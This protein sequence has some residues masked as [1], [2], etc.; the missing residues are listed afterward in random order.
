MQQYIKAIFLKE[1]KHRF[2]CLVRINNEEEICYVASSSKLSHFIKL[3]NQEVLLRIINKKSSK[4]R[5]ALFAAK[6]NDTYILLDLVFTN[7]LIVE[8]LTNNKI[9]KFKKLQTEYKFENGYKTDILLTN[10]KLETIIEIKSIISVENF[11]NFPQLKM[12]RICNQLQLLKSLLIQGYNVYFWLVSLN[13]DCKKIIIN[14]DD[15]EFKVL[16]TECCSLGMKII[17]STIKWAKNK[18]FI[19]ETSTGI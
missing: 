2:K 9:L 15:T 10:N 18:Q 16:Y 14:E 1:C 19:I 7:K 3:E 17:F 4:L 13:P 6:Y 8:Y 11:A 12:Q 5:Y